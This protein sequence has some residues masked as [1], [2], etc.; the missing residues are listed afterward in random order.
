MDDDAP[1]ELL[2]RF[3]AEHEARCPAC[4]YELHGLVEARC[5][6]CKQAL[7]LT[8]GM[9]RPR[10]TLFVLA[11]IPSAFSLMCAALLFTLMIIAFVN[12]GAPPPA[13]LMVLDAFGFLSGLVGV[14]MIARPYVFLGQTRARQLNAVSL[15][16]G[17][18]IAAF[19][20]LL[21]LIVW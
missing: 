13:G 2:L 16:W 17:V 8:V 19:L 20:V 10:V 9:P 11:L 18:H 6:E 7:E 4:G 15:A 21:A 1:P 5:P 14:T 12:E 3:L